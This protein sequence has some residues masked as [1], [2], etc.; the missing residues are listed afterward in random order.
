MVGFGSPDLVVSALLARIFV[1]SAAG[2]FLNMG[3]SGLVL[4]QG[5][6]TVERE[7]ARSTSV[8][9]GGFDFLVAPFELRILSL[10]P[11][12][13]VCC[14]TSGIISLTRKLI[15]LFTSDIH[16]RLLSSNLVDSDAV[17]LAPDYFSYSS[18]AAATVILDVVQG[19]R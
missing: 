10:T 7:V 14:V 17:S 8:F 3:G 18:M 13:E 15:L 12:L 16:L 19:P 2:D 6:L 1:H 11:T 4:V 5:K 9:L